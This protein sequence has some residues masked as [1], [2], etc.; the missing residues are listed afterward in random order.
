M[1]S[2]AA[3]AVYARRKLTEHAHAKMK[4]RGFGRMPVHGRATVRSVCL[5]HAIAHNMLHTQGRRSA[6]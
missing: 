4:N 3:K 5:L 6:A 1:E 2:E